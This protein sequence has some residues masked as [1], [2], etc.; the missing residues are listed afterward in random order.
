MPGSGSRGGC[1]PFWLIID[2]CPASPAVPILPPLSGRAASHRKPSP[3]L[4]RTRHF[5]RTALKFRLR[6]SP[7]A[8]LASGE[9]WREARIPCDQPDPAATGKRDRSRCHMGPPAG[10]ALTRRRAGNRANG[11]L[12]VH[13]GARAKPYG[14]APE[15]A[16]GHS[17]CE[18]LFVSLSASS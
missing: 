4:K 14:F 1:T 8:R 16:E 17:Q 15:R 3:C 11:G 5:V 12:S 13:P 18:S 6:P 10:V 2:G 9:R 7:R